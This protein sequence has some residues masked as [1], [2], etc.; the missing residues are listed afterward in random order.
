MIGISQPYVFVSNGATY[1]HRIDHA[2]SILGPGDVDSS[3][4][5]KSPCTNIFTL[6]HFRSK[7]KGLSLNP[8]ATLKGVVLTPNLKVATF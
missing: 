6:S 3:K 1:L 4:S 2:Q 7:L 8:R 5:D